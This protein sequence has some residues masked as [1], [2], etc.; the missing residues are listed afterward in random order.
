MSKLMD[1]IIARAKTV[2]KHIVLAEGEEARIIDAALII[3]QQGIATLTLLGDREVILS[4]VE[5]GALDGVNIVNPETSDKLEEYAHLLY[6][7]R[8]AKGMTEEKALELAKR[9]LY[10]GC[11]MVKSGDADGLV[12]GSITATSEVLRPALQIIKTKP[13]IKTVSGCFVMGMPE[14][15]PYGEN[16]VMIFADCAVM[17]DPTAEQLVDIAVA[18]AESA[19][20]VCGM[21]E[22]KVAM[23]SFSTKGSASHPNVDK[24]QTATATLK[25]MDLDFDVDGEL[26][27]DAALVPT[28][29]A[30]KAPGSTVAGHANVLVF[31]DLQSG[32]I[33]YKIAQRFGGV[34]AIGPLCQGLAL[35]VND[36]SRGCSVSDVVGVVAI[37]ALQ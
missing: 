11:L 18:S 1:G 35:P 7:L 30:L 17:P 24:V 4:K 20:N 33:G 14:G 16:G 8:K 23:L 28:V 5:E 36:L 29:G 26:Q 2:N 31:P 9:P 13:G 32:N 34:E 15:S 12:G 19:R 27:L 37:T 25:S 6:E 3:K 21:K 22:P 10:Y